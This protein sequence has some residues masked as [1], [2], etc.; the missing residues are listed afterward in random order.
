MADEKAQARTYRRVAADIEEVKY[1]VQ[2]IDADV[3]KRAPEL[4]TSNTAELRDVLNTQQSWQNLLHDLEKPQALQAP[5]PVAA[6][7]ARNKPEP[8]AGAADELKPGGDPKP[9]RK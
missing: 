6:A 4:A 3:T 1:I 7:A 8:G 2:L 5:S 9:P